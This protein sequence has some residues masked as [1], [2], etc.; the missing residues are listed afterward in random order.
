M[1]LFAA[2][3]IDYAD[4]LVINFVLPSIGDE[5]DLSHSQQGLV[6]SVFF[7]AYA[8][9]QIPGGVLA[10]RIGG[11]RMVLWALGAWTVCTALTG[12][13]WSFAALLVLRVLFGLAQGV[14][15]PAATKVLVERSQP[16]ERMRANGL[17][18]SSNSL[19][20]VFTP[21]AVAPLVAA[22]GWR[23]AYLSI[24]ALGVFVYVALRLRLP[25]PL[26][27]R[28]S[29][30]SATP[31]ADTK[32][33]LKWGVLWRFAA[34]MF[35]Y[36][37]IIW[38]L[39]SWVPTYLKDEHG[40]DL[41]AAGALMAIPGLAA[42]LATVV[43]GRWVDG[44]GGRHR[45]IVVP[46]MGVA[47]VALP[48]M[49]NAASVALFVALATVAVFAAAL[50]YMPIMAV[51]IRSLSPA[52]I[53]VASGILVFGGQLAGIVAPTVMGVLAD[54]FSFHVA[55]T[56]LALGPVIAMVMACLTP[57]DTETF[58]AGA[59]DR[60]RTAAPAPDRTNEKEPA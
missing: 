28:R 55:F 33:L 20:A 45:R 1:L 47:A 23:S 21:L 6:V 19:A 30:P 57:Q 38:G 14:F 32:A 26:P 31:G 34:M 18:L 42:A 7:L 53:G 37:L 24:A 27:D 10:D 59:D 16:Q 54:A 40:V 43:G 29:L 56:F 48:V 50:C 12:L 15:P 35:G 17:I 25:S 3:F 39:S 13:A 44:T 8:V 4:R 22:F 11:R 60:V 46:A 5:F 51:P 2:W 9:C 58:L 36:S 49:A 41:H 52:H